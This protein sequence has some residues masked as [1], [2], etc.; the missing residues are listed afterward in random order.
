M[1]D[2]TPQ[3]EK[4][5]AIGEAAARMLQAQ[6]REMESDILAAWHAAEA[7]A[8]VDDGKPV[9]KIGFSIALD[10]DADSLTCTT[11]ISIRKKIETTE[12]IPDPNQPELLP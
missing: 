9:L 10:L 12:T 3:N 5:A 8:L 11:A 4:L 2:E 1:E 7:Q 6:I